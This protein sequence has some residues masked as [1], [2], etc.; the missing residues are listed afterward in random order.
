MGKRWITAVLA[1]VIGSTMLVSP[2][3]ASLHPCAVAAQRCE[4]TLEV[5]LNWADPQS[6]KISVRFVFKPHSDRTRPSAGAIVALSGGPGGNLGQLELMA[7]PVQPL[8][9]TYDMLIVQRRGFGASSALHCDNVDVYEPETITACAGHLGPRIQYFTTDQRVADINAVR[10]ALGIPKLVLYGSSYGSLDGPAFAARFPQH[11]EAAIFDS[12]TLIPDQ[13]TGYAHGFLGQDGMNGLMGGLDYA[14]ERSR[15]CR[16][17]PGDT[18]SRMAKVAQQLRA[19]PDPEVSLAKL[20]MAA[21]GPDPMTTRSINAALDAY[22][23]GDP[24]PLRRLA[25][26]DDFVDD[27]NGFLRMVGIGFLSYLCNDVAWPYS[28]EAIPAQRKEQLAEYY[29]RNPE[30]PVTTAETNGEAGFVPEWCVYWPTRRDAPPVPPHATYPNIP[31]LA[32]AGTLDWGAATNAVALAD[33]YRS[34]RALIVPFAG[35]ATSTYP[36]AETFEACLS[37]AIQNFI[38]GRPA[39]SSCS[40]E[41]FAAIGQFPLRSADLLTTTVQ[42]AMDALASRI[43]NS[44]IM[45]TRDELPGLRGGKV[46]YDG[47]KATLHEV[48]Y[49]TDTVVSGEIRFTETQAEADLTANGKRVQLTWKP[50]EAKETMWVTGS[51]DGK[52]FGRWLPVT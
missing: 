23:N 11:V 36:S 8:L 49:T 1:G 40:A 31:V 14:C 17:L 3:A 21:G 44:Y 41:N 20:V 12:P 48:R 15:A 45:N 37:T 34:G 47:P 30:Y 46:T 32:I 25:G 42:T 43:P 24:A 5:P 52:R 10:A 16:A 29:E 13:R 39:A 28:R 18:G 6:E 27:P 2:A 7:K 38:I 35:H 4:G 51:V 9:T 33:R 26:L 19:K 22:L 50:F